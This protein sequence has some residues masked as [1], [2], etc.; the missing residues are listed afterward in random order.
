MAQEALSA[1]TLIGDPA[2]LDAVFDYAE[3]K[4]APVRK[5]AIMAAQIMGGKYAAAWLFTMSTG[6]EDAS[7]RQLAELALMKVEARLKDEQKK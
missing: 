6:H 5:K 7:V 2:G 3:R 4:P 1:L